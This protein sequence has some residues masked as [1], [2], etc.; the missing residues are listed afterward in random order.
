MFRTDRQLDD[1]HI[2]LEAHNCDWWIFRSSNADS[3]ITGGSDVKNNDVLEAFTV[4]PQLTSWWPGSVIAAAGLGLSAFAPNVIFLYFSAGVLIGPLISIKHICSFYVYVSFL[5]SNNCIS[6]VCSSPT[7][8]LT[9]TFCE[10]CFQMVLFV[11]LG[12]AIIYFITTILSSPRAES[13]RAFTGRRCSH[14]GKGEDF[15]TGQPDFFTETAVTPER[16]VEKSFPR[17]EIN[18]HAE[19]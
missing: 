19:G 3:Q 8:H 18:R 1:K 7:N 9:P 11:G 17:W 13:A 14:S 2:G 5:G 15:L 16:K 10:Y 12:L 6:S 4:D